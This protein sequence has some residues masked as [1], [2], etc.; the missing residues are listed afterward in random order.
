M[1]DPLTF[2][3]IFGESERER[4]TERNKE[5]EREN[6]TEREREKNTEREREKKKNRRGFFCLSLLMLFFF[7]SFFFNQDCQNTLT[8]YTKTASIVSPHAFSGELVGSPRSALNS[9]SRDAREKLSSRENRSP[10]PKHRCLLLQ[11][12]SIDAVIRLQRLPR[13]CR[14]SG[15]RAPPCGLS[16]RRTLAEHSSSSIVSGEEGERGRSRFLIFQSCKKIDTSEFSQ[17][18]TNK[19]LN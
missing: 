17:P 6:D 19:N 7:L 5:R 15:L 2:F 14:L 10:I 12:P 3:G 9:R 16:S 11:R 8:F 1:N 13:R 4:E 18:K